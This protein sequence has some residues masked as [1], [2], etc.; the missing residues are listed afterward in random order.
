MD[1]TPPRQRPGVQSDGSRSG[2]CI[3]Q[4]TSLMYVRTKANSNPE[5]SKDFLVLVGLS[6]LIAFPIAWLTMHN[7]LKDYAYRI[8][9]SLWIFVI[10]GA[11]AILIALLTI[12]F[13][14]I[15]TAR[16]N[17]VKSLRSE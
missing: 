17:P 2:N 15:R 16:A 5:L 9:I 4:A 7:W 10:S 11:L 13:Q 12:S 8:D 3:P 1:T 14:A 6:C